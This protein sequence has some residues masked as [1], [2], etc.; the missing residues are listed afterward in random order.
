MISLD[1]RLEGDVLS[2]RPSMIKFKGL[3]TN[4]EI[5]GSGLRQL[6]M[7]L[8]RQLIKI[9]EDLG[10]TNHALLKLQEAAVEN[11]RSTTQS[12]INAASFLERSQIGKSARL[13]WLLRK[14]CYIDIHFSDDALLRNT[15]ELA[16]LV[17]LRELKHSM[18]PPYS[19]HG[20]RTKKSMVK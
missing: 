12:P 15:L 3:D 20:R 7:Y 4:L 17:Q 18:Y 9:L 13:P 5:C 8:N 19:H 6:P 2:L 16:V 10:V 14:L 1:T 11:L